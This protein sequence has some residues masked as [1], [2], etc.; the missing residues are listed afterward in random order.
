[1]KKSLTAET[2]ETAEKKTLK[3]LGVLRGKTP[4][5]F[6]RSEGVSRPTGLERRGTR[7]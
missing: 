5:F 2:A 3:I 4:H 6:A 1:V 7:R